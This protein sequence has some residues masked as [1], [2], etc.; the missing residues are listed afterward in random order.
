MA[1]IG[2]AT[3]MEIAANIGGVVNTA[4]VESGVIVESAGDAGPLA[5]VLE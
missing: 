2:G 3:N 5:S 1:S 4:I